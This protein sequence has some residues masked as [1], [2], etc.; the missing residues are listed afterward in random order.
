MR[1][2]SREYWE[3]WQRKFSTGT[4]ADN[5]VGDLTPSRFSWLSYRFLKLDTVFLLEDLMPESTSD[6][7]FQ[8][9]RGDD[10]SRKISQAV[11]DQVWRRDG[12]QCV[13][14]GSQEHLE[15]DHIIPFAKGGASTY[16]NIQ[17]LCETCNRRKSDAIG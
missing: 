7:F 6:V 13:E 8:A 15:F 9:L 12:G 10:R 3:Q 11:K 14:C 5:V 1:S 16:R 17:L 4:T 2:E